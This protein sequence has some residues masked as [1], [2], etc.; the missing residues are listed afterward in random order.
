M[1]FT[2]FRRLPL[3]VLPALLF[4]WVGLI[5]SG[6][7]VAGAS[8]TQPTTKP[9]AP[10]ARPP[11]PEAPFSPVD[12]A[13]EAESTY[14]T[15][16]GIE[17]DLNADPVVANIQSQMKILIG[18]IDARMDE[19]TKLLA[20]NPS[21]QLLGAQEQDWLAIQRELD[22]WREQLVRRSGQ[23]KNEQ[24]LLKDSLD[25][26]QAVQVLCDYYKTFGKGE[27]LLQKAEL[28]IHKSQEL[29]TRTTADV[30]STMLEVAKVRS[31]VNLQAAKV[32]DILDS[33]RRARDDAFSR[34]FAQ[35]SPP[36]WSVSLRSSESASMFEQGRDSLER[37]LQAVGAYITRRRENVAIQM[38]LLVGLA[39]GLRWLKSRMQVWVGQDPTLAKP[40]KVF[41]SPLA[42]ALVISLLF[43]GSIYPQAPRLLWA[44]IGAAALIPTVIILR[45]LI[46]RRWFSILDALVV[47]YFLD[48]LRSIS[49]VVPVLARI[50]L[51]IEML[52]G[53]L[54][55]I[56]FTRSIQKAE[57]DLRLRRA[58]ITITLIWMT[59][60]LLSCIGVI[61]GYVSVAELMGNGALSSAYL[62]VI[63]YACTLILQGL[64]I[65]AVRSRPLRMLRMMRNH[66]PVIVARV[67]RA[68]SWAAVGAWMIGVL[69][70]LSVAT[71]AYELAVKVFSAHLTLGSI[72]VSL[73]DVLKF[74]LTVWGSFV[75]SRFLRFVLEEDV[76]DRFHLPSGIPYAISKLLNY[77]VLLAGF[78][79]A[80]SALGFDMNK[81]T[82]LVGAF[83]VG[84]GFGLQNI[85]NNFF[86]GLILLFE[87][88][89]KVG[90]VI[91][92]GDTT[93]VVGHI[94][95]RASILRTRD[96]SEIIVPN[97]NLI[98]SQVTNWTLSNR[99]RGVE[100][101]MNLGSDADPAKVIALLIRV[102]AANPRVAKNPCPEAF[103]TKFSGDSFSY[104]LRAWTDAA[105]QWI[106]LRSELSVAL[107]QEL[108]KENIAIK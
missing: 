42:S 60:F 1:T 8:A 62:A 57:L 51:L 49:A 12:A 48:Q 33:I 54:L 63:I 96:S 103:L 19:S 68:M 53:F 58:V 84:L 18:E 106:L 93:G 5:C 76:Y 2:R 39:I 24:A 92:M 69:A 98:S 25:R 56:S 72:S 74:S 99:Q 61:V 41:G 31:D 66:Q 77:V 44:M 82:I 67:V 29:L 17:T 108:L 94:G 95:I 70:S 97:G 36:L 43:S 11:A 104:Q 80:V 15:A 78:F 85:I 34:L 102:A 105:D 14:I 23:L 3:F 28:S 40:T 101:D 9:T 88:P 64:L 45:R 55:L 7:A 83:G 35:N 59:S 6:I 4:L 75:L 16:R 87:R 73:G 13:T 81:F 107:N 89:I 90:D 37:Q 50:L 100:I 21:L 32:L 79:I 27:D 71:V 65:I 47:F 26:W 20:S 38:V 46:D 30:S 86:S 10:T 52:G 91:Q 22:Q